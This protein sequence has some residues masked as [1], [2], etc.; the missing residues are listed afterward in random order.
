MSSFTAEELDLYQDL[1]YF[2]K[3]EI[4]H[5]FKRF[6]DV[7]PN[8]LIKQD[9]LNRKSEVSLPLESFSNLEELRVNP[10]RERICRVFSS[11][12]DCSLTFEDFLDL[13]SVMS[14]HSPKSLKTEYAFRVYDF[15][16]DDLIGPQDIATVI[17]HLLGDQNDL[18][19][20]ETQLIVK[21]VIDEADLDDDRH[22]SFAEFEHVAS[23]APDFMTSFRIRL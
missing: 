22:L 7:A 4:L 11:R 17:K 5:V 1:T 3:K 2:S 10:F 14:E 23:K 21:N 20:E 19:D 9:I 13:M 6:L 16:G 18:T 15:D 8:E 12:L